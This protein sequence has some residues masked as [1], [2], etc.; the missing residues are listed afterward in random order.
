MK[1]L[2]GTKTQVNLM[3]AFIGESAAR[4][5]YTY[6]ASVAKNEGYKQIEAIFAETADQEKEHAK[7]LFRFMGEAGAEI[8][9]T[10]TLPAGPERDTMQNLKDAA[11]GEN[12]EWGH[13][14][15]EYA[16]V[17]DA[18]GFPEIA[19]VMRNIAIAE[20]AHEERFLAFAK[21]IA[22]GKV[23]KKDAKVT[24]RCRNCGYTCE[25]ASAPDKCPACDHPQAH[26]ELKATNW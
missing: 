12:H 17:A 9:G 20:K 26:F 16:D 18:E 22:D 5:R 23:F 15:P 19:T 11:A 24:W 8:T 21:N 14:Y 7:R 3:N 10:M 1:S 13:M 25:G 2:K 4:N 6:Y